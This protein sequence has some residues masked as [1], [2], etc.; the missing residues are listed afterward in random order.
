MYVF[1]LQS[2]ATM[3]DDDFEAMFATTSE[4]KSPLRRGLSRSSSIRS[5][6]LLAMIVLVALDV[7][8]LIKII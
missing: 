4:S 6:K 8:K 5:I 7:N 2:G 3:A 1:L